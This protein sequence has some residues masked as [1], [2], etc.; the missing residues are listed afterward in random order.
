MYRL[1]LGH[2]A[3][4]APGPPRMALKKKY[5]QI[6]LYCAT[7]TKQ[8]F[9]HFIYHKVLWLYLASFFGFVLKQIS[10]FV[11]CPLCFPAFIFHIFKI[12]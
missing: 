7:L 10:E 6:I 2:V 4:T 5:K 11:I 3:G 1:Q 9:M 8:N 12:E